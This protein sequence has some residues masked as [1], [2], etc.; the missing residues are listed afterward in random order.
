PPPDYAEPLRKIATAH[1]QRQS[2]MD[3]IDRHVQSKPHNVFYDSKQPLMSQLSTLK[4]GIKRDT[5]SIDHLNDVEN[6]LSGEARFAHLRTL[7][8]N[9]R[10]Q[11]NTIIELRKEL[12][13]L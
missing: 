2:V 11:R 1:Q 10:S 8:E 3:N 5:A 4:E 7:H 13:L 12:K 6:V 9:N